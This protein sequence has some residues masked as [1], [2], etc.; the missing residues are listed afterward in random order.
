MLVIAPSSTFYF[1]KF[2]LKKRSYDI[3]KPEHVPTNGYELK[4]LRFI[5]HG[6]PSY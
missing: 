4:D 3:F 2:C 1:F 5:R 6:D